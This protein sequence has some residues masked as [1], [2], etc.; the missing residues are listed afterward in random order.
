MSIA[1]TK[2]PVSPKGHP[3]TF[4]GYWNW[5]D[6]GYSFIGQGR[7]DAVLSNKPEDRRMVFEEAAGIT[8]FKKRK[9]ESIKK[10]QET[11][12]NLERIQDLLNVLKKQELSLSDDL[13]RYYDYK[14]VYEKRKSL[15]EDFFVSEYQNFQDRKAK[16]QELIQEIW[17]NGPA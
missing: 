1:S 6:A 7:I 13:K 12:D 9:N 8:K 5:E 4:Y 16:V 14:E 2:R 3:R 11:L 17:G 10:L 15:D